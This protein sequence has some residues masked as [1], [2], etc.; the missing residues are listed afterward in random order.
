MAPQPQAYADD[1][2]IVQE[3][4]RW[5]LISRI[6][7]RFCLVYFTLYCSTNQILTGLVPLE[8]GT[9][10]PVVKMVEWT[11]VHVFHVATP[12]VYSGSGSGDKTFDWVLA[13]C[14]FS[15]AVI[16]AAI[17]SVADRRRGEYRT[18]Q[19][20]FYVFLRFAAG[21][22]MLIY[23][24][25]K[26]VPLQMPFPS[27]TRLV[28]PFGNFSPMGVLWYSIGAAPGYEMFAGSAEVLG[29]VLLFFPRTAMLGAMVVLADSIEIFT[30]NMTYDVPVKLFAFHLIVMSLILLAPEMGRIWRFFLSRDAV[31]ASKR[32]DLFQ[33]PRAN[34]IAFAVQAV[35]A[36]WLI[37]AKSYGSYQG[38]HLYGAGAPKSPLYG[39]WNVD[40][41][42]RD[43]SSIRR[44]IFDRPTGMS[45]QRV[46]DTFTGY[47]AQV[48]TQNGVVTLKQ[49]N[50]A[51]TIKFERTAPDRMTLA[52]L[53]DGQDL[54]M[55][56]ELLDR[57]K[58]L[59]VSRGFHWVQEYPFNR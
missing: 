7:F 3:P 15:I 19:K 22:Q 48:D 16:S 8:L 13:F 25:A 12:L 52:G 47:G 59:L 38:W 17:W 37:G 24:M 4:Q 33:S 50:S 55:K 28:E 53:I 36:L 56:L 27:L 6:A 14:L 2:E 44:V 5:P 26:L 21:S 49:N 30:L 45:L 10:G 31:G 46:D 51:W 20:W 54:H 29:G 35:F 41:V 39:I 32:A 42:S 43:A 1:I 57:S 23:G 40:K 9:K 11:A 18:A 34:R 58:L